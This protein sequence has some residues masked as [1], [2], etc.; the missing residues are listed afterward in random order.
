MLLFIFFLFLLKVLPLGKP[1]NGQMLSEKYVHFS[2][3]NGKRSVSY[4]LDTMA[5]TK[6]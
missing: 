2:F 1:L 4:V 5:T 3:I 6:K